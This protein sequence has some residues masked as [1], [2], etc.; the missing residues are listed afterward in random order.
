MSDEAATRLPSFWPGDAEACG[1]LAWSLDFIRRA[2]SKKTV[3]DG[4]IVP[5]F[6]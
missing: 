3:G 4:K 2:F 5:F 6:S 1:P